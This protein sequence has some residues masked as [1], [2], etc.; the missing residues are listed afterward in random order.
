MKKLILVLLLCS[1]FPFAVNAERY[2]SDTSL[3]YLNGSDYEVGDP[4]RHVLT[5]EY[6]G[7][8][9]W[10][11]YSVLLTGWSLITATPKLILSFHLSSTYLSLRITQ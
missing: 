2:W 8:Y 3:T 11:K 1:S 5:L 6:V 4:D 10:G 9:S 7:G